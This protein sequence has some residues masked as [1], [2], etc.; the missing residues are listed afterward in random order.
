MPIS[1]SMII[2]SSQL[3]VTVADRVPAF[4]IDRSCKLDVAATAGLSID[5]SL[6][7][8]VS[9][10]KRARQKLASQWSRFS[11]AGKAECIPQESIGGTPSYV[12]LLTCLQ[13]GQWSR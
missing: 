4:D 5:Q 2:V 8:C 12:S 11:A 1:I 6:K 13:M 10:E 3:V 7:S 9:D